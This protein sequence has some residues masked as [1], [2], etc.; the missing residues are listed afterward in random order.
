MGVE[1]YSALSSEMCNKTQ[2]EKP[3]TTY[4]KLGI[5]SQKNIVAQ[6]RLGWNLFTMS[7]TDPNVEK[8]YWLVILKDN[9]NSTVIYSE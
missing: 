4:T 2:I 7:K 6:C 5:L 9:I 8:N 1:T 3:S